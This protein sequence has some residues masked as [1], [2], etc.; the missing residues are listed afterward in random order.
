MKIRCSPFFSSPR[1]SRIKEP[2]FLVTLKF[3]EEVKEV[4]APKAVQEVLD[5]F[6]N[7]MPAELPKRISPKRE[8]GHAIELE[9]RAKPPAFAPYRMVPP[10]LE[11]LRR[12]LKELLDAGYICVFKSPYGASVLFQK[13]H[14]GSL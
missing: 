9:P 12:Q 7:V 10:E 5:D 8:V 4:Q 14:D 11:E 1:E 6:K 2:T 13:K 3:D